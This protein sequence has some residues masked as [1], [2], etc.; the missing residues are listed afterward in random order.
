[1]ILQ[2]VLDRSLGNFT[3]LRGYAALG[4]LYKVSEPDSSYQRD[5]ISHQ[6]HRMEKFLDDGEYL[7]FPEV[8]LGA[9]LDDGSNPAQVTQ[10]V[11][12]FDEDK[13]KKYKFSKFNLNYS[14]TSR[15]TG[16]ESRETI[17]YRRASLTVDDKL[18]ELGGFDMFHRIDGNHRLS[19][20]SDD[21]ETPL[22]E[23]KIQRYSKLNV[24]YCLVLFNNDNDLNRFSRALFHNVNYRQIALT[25]EQS[26]KQI[27]EDEELFS[28][29]TLMEKF[30]AEYLL[31]RK[32]LQSWDLTMIS[33]IAKVIDSNKNDLV[34]KRTFLLKTFEN[35]AKNNLVTLEE[36][37]VDKEVLKF[38]RKLSEINSEYT[39]PRLG[40]QRNSGLLSAFFYYAY[41][42]ESKLTI[43]KNWVLENHIYQTHDTQALEII[44]IFDC[45]LEARSRTIFVSMQFSTETEENYKAIQDAVSKVNAEF[46]LSL[47][48][49]EIRI[50]QFKKGYSY[51][52][53][54]ELLM[55]IE[56]CGLLIADISLGN[57][58]VYHEIGYLMGLNKGAVKS[59]D[60]FILLHNKQVAG[61]DF[62]KDHGFNIKTYQVLCA[63]GT[64]SLRNQIKE[65][66]KKY[67]SLI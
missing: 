15:K 53:D 36:Q 14:V 67:Y 13:G 25:M 49:R 52:I 50:D 29:A 2:G 21:L 44:K 19:I 11:Y 37:D 18:L 23:D 45:V 7:F 28:N 5:L 4:D 58:N 56:D 38:K 16:R 62:N 12:E 41:Q 43:F 65:Q 39:H 59:Q 3:C 6:Q 8:I 55:L 47:K 24:P 57:K 33:N 26:L 32:V 54:D 66:I 42:P 10:F 20:L 46:S 60:N 35:L 34:S 17:L 22:T 9:S 1:M 27:L 51:K 63:D 48:I 31:A 61:S 40:E 30:G 64:N